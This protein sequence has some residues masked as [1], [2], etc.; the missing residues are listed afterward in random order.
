MPGNND[1]VVKIGHR[2]HAVFIC[3]VVSC[4]S[5]CLVTLS[6]L[7]A[8]NVTHCSVEHAMFVQLF[9]TC[10]VC[11]AVCDVCAAVLDM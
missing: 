10:D 4:V 8:C 6:V 11:S 2:T 3:S 5:V 7:L 9:G 1:Q